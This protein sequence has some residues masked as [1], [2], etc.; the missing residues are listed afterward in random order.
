[1]FKTTRIIIALLCTLAICSFAV[2]LV[3]ASWVASN[4]TI[5]MLLF[6]CFPIAMVIASLGEV[7]VLCLWK[8]L[9]PHDYNLRLSLQRIAFAFYSRFCAIQ[10][11]VYGFLYKRSSPS[12]KATLYDRFKAINS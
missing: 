7:V 4:R 9:V 11:R 8:W 6:F 1:M 2:L 12:K 10:Y 5:G 3:T